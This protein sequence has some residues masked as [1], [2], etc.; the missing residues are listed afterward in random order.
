MFNILLLTPLIIEFIQ[1]SFPTFIEINIR[2]TSVF[3]SF[4]NNASDSRIRTD[5]KCLVIYDLLL[6]S[7]IVMSGA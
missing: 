6:V 4:R 5:F 1:D 3:R 2:R 7:S